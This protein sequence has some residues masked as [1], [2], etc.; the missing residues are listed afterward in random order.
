MFVAKKFDKIGLAPSGRHIRFWG[1]RYAAPMELNLCLRIVFYKHSTPTELT[2]KITLSDSSINRPFQ[3]KGE[4]FH[5]LLIPRS[6]TST[7]TR[8]SG[9]KKRKTAA[10]V[11]QAVSLL[12][13]V[14]K[15]MA[16]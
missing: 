11:E 6:E 2:S 1:G 16:S 10:R 14:T 8:L 12:K 9:P 7:V 13:A 5:T 4:T 3:R 15:T